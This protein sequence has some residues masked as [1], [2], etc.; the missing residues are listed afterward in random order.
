MTKPPRTTTPTPA[1]PPRSPTPTPTRPSPPNQHDKPT[2]ATSLP[3][4]FVTAVTEVQI[5]LP[6]LQVQ[7]RFN[8]SSFKLL[9]YFNSHS[10]GY[11]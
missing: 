9:T 11:V 8:F 2:L 10:N 3:S 1:K 5:M 7:V 6:N 4:N